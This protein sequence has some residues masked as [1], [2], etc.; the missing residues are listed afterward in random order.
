MANWSLLVSSFPIALAVVVPSASAQSRTN[1]PERDQFYLHASLSTGYGF[2]KLTYS[3]LSAE[4]MPRPLTFHDDL[5]GGFIAIDAAPGYALSPGLA[6]G[7]EVRGSLYPSLTSTGLPYTGLD[8]LLL[9]Y[10]GPVVDWYP[11]ASRP[12]HVEMGAGG[13]IAD[14]GGGQDDIGA[15]DNIVNLGELQQMVGVGAHAGVGYMWR[16]SGGFDYGPS[17]RAEWTHFTSE[18]ATSDV[19]AV[20]GGFVVSWF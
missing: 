11:D 13:V 7:L 10:A 1:P 20:A 9:G 6:L 2:G 4:I 5:R 14:F 15:A 17:I 8:V 18:H 16:T 19:F 3:G 12:L